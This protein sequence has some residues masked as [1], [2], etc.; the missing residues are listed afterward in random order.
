MTDSPTD[1]PSAWTPRG[2]QQPASSPAPIEAVA[3]A[4]DAY[5]ASLSDEEFDAMVQRTRSR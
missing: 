3:L 5:V 1:Y 4:V 2:A